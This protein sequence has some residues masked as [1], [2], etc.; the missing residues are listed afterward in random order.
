MQSLASKLPVRKYCSWKFL[1]VCN[2]AIRELCFYIADRFEDSNDIITWN[3][4]RRL[5]NRYEQ[6]TKQNH[7]L[8]SGKLCFLR[9]LHAFKIGRHITQHSRAKR[10]KLLFSVTLQR[11]NIASKHIFNPACLKSP[12]H[13]HSTACPPCLCSWALLSHLIGRE[14]KRAFLTS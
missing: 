12:L 4:S 5:W 8:L 13:C 3:I 9:W 2:A 1:S 7:M 14:V 11:L 10:V 6:K